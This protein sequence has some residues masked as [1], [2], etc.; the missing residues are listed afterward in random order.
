MGYRV[1]IYPKYGHLRP[2]CSL[3]LCWG[4]NMSCKAW[5]TPK[6]P[7]ATS[8]GRGRGKGEDK[9]PCPESEREV[10]AGQFGF[11]KDMNALGSLRDPE[12]KY[13]RGL[14]DVDVL[15][16]ATREVEHRM[17]GP[18][19]AW[20]IWRRELWFGRYLLKRYNVLT[21]HLFPPPHPSRP[22]KN[23][24]ILASP[25]PFPPSCPSLSPTLFAISGYSCSI[26]VVSKL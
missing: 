14:S 20:Q 13:E 12:H 8:W 22:P 16:G 4:L 25:R 21:H 19:R 7:S 15:L 17:Q 10:F 18:Q 5:Q 26:L 3:T 23:R 6:Q 24:L 11:E 9:T 2:C 1:F